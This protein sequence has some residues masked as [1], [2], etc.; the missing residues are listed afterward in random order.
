MPDTMITMTRSDPRASARFER[1]YAEARDP[2]VRYLARRAAPDAVE[3]L[4]ADTMTIAWRRL[5]EI[6]H[7]AE[8]P[9]LYGTARRVLANQRRATGRFAR[10]IEKLAS[11]GHGVDL[12]TGPRSH[13]DPDLADALVAL[14][15]TDAEILRLWAWEELTPTEIGTALGISAN[16]AS[17]RL[18]RAKRRLRDQLEAMGVANAGKAA[19]AAG[20][21]P[22]VER[23]EAR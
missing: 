1:L 7:G 6:P 13:A 5:D 9:W 16:A 21:V 22:S 20:H 4:F 14:A 15:A 11:F 17:I 8:V 3:D 12:G 19:P 2:L 18:H 10:L 23:K